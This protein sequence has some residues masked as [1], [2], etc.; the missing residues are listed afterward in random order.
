METIAAPEQSRK[1]AF[2]RQCEECKK[3][4]NAFQK[5]SKFC[6][7]SCRAKWNKKHPKQAA[8][9]AAEIVLET[10]GNKPAA[11]PTPQT[12]FSGLSPHM[13]IA[14][15]LLQKECKRW[16][17]AYKEEKKERIDL[18]E[19]LTALKDQVRED[20]HKQALQGIEDE[21]PSMFERVLGS[22]PPQ[23]MEH[24]APVIGQLAQRLIP[25]APGAAMAGVEG[26]LD[27]GQIQ[28]LSWVAQQPE[29]MQKK[30]IL[31]CT[32]L[33]QMQPQQVALNLDKVLNLLKNGTTMTSNTMMGYGT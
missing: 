32:A 9:E 28:F 6:S 12:I 25:A 4:Y 14:V 27:E 33:M 17:E 5:N 18:Q 16:E 1:K 24:L 31:L 26:Q 13:Q 7:G 21:K 23:V 30:I 3:D 2:T 20:A 15:D 29:P 11:A 8:E 22:I 10:T 19:K